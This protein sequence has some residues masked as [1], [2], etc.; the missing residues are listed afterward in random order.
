MVVSD[1]RAPFFSKGP[2]QAKGPDS[3]LANGDEVEVLRK[4]FGY[5]FVQLENGQT[6]YVANDAVVTAPPR[7][8]GEDASS[9]IK[10]E[11]N[12]CL[13]PDFRY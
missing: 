2:A 7:A 13:L 9:E 5:S 1:E 6:G 4:E 11:S 10:P 8:P 3:M 12:P